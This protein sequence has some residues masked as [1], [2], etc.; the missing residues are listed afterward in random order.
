M[1]G[2][3]QPRSLESQI[4]LD[5]QAVKNYLDNVLRN[6][7]CKQMTPKDLEDFIRAKVNEKLDSRERDH[8]TTTA[9]KEYPNQYNAGKEMQQY[10]NHCVAKLER[11]VDGRRPS[12]NEQDDPEP[13]PKRHRQFKRETSPDDGTSEAEESETTT[14]EEENDESDEEHEDSEDDELD[15]QFEPKIVCRGFVIKVEEVGASGVRVGT[16]TKAK[17]KTNLTSLNG[18]IAAR[19]ITKEQKWKQ[20]KRAWKWVDGKMVVWPPYDATD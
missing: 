4:Q 1:G 12:E 8:R 7:K 19:G 16:K 13:L 18:K 2:N 17:G 15:K 20:A 10:I 3:D 14:N 9:R 11:K 6:S 5:R